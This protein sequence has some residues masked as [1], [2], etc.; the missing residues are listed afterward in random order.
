[1]TPFMHVFLA[2]KKTG[3]VTCGLHWRWDEC[4]C[5]ELENMHPFMV[6]EQKELMVKSLLTSKTQRNPSRLFGVRA[7]MNEA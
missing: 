7:F 2:F 3:R 6:A 5:V 1:M 4:I